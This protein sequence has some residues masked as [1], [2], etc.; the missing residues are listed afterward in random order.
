[1]PTLAN[2]VS[3]LR[4]DLRD[5]GGDRWPT[6]TLERH[7]GRAAREL[8]AFLPQEKKT[9]LETT[10]GS[11]DVSIATLA[12][13]VRVEA[14]EWPTGRYPRSLVAFSVWQTTLTLLVDA[15]PA[16]VENVFVYWGAQHV[17]DT[18]GSSVPSYAEETLLLGAAGYAAVEWA[19]F[20]TN[21]ANVSGT[22]AVEDYRRW[23]ED[24]LR[25]FR[26]GLRR[27]GSRVRSGRLYV[28]DEAATGRDTVSF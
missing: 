26:A 21:R 3:T 4:T 22:E 13:L 18:N 17:I 2:L 1:V 11:R 14:V 24:R 23:G 20:A 6:A 10:G 28:P 5:S 27:L 8:S 16:G 12:D 25:Q 7:I 15:P 9:T 19:S